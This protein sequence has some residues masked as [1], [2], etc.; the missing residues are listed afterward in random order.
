MCA[1]ICLGVIYVRHIPFPTGSK[2]YVILWEEVWKVLC[3]HTKMEM[4]LRLRQIV[5]RT[6]FKNVLVNVLNVP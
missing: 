3:R 2:D 1:F 6:S 5:A 4:K